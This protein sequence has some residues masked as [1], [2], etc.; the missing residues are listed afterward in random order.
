[1]SKKNEREREREITIPFGDTTIPEKITILAIEFRKREK[2][3][4]LFSGEFFTRSLILK[5]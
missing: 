5:Q 3:K 1:M 4:K 2:E